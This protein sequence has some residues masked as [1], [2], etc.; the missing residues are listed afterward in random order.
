MAILGLDN[1][2]LS[3]FQ[4]I[5]TGSQIPWSRIFL[6]SGV[7]STGA[8]WYAERALTIPGLIYLYKGSELKTT[9]DITSGRNHSW[10]YDCYWG[11]T[12]GFLGDAFFVPKLAYDGDTMINPVVK[13]FD[14]ITE[15]WTTPCSEFEFDMSSSYRDHMFSVDLA[16]DHQDD[17]L[18]LMFFR[19]RRFRTGSTL[20]GRIFLY[21]LD[22]D[23]VKDHLITD[24]TFSVGSTSITASRGRISISGSNI[25]IATTLGLLN[26]WYYNAIA[27]EDQ[28]PTERTSSTNAIYRYRSFG[29]YGLYFRGT[30]YILRKTGS[31]TTWD[32][33]SYITSTYGWGIIQKIDNTEKYYIVT[34]DSTTA[35]SYLLYLNSDGTVTKK[36]NQTV[37]LGGSPNY[38]WQKGSGL[39]ATEGLYPNNFIFPSSMQALYQLPDLWKEVI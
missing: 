5:S 13:R 11:D 38:P 16:V 39:Y 19:A 12:V 6:G 7:D 9:M 14:L 26:G 35:I 22:S 29:N 23:G 34:Y 32:V 18:F 30:D 10:V 2:F 37:T 27:D 33:S 20:A 4:K 36:D 15:E 24:K 28:D 17:R 1:S 3:F 21:E 31:G 8:R 25:E